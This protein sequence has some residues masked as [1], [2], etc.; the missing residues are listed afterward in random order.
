MNERGNKRPEEPDVGV[1]VAPSS[2]MVLKDQSEK[3]EELTTLVKA[4]IE[5][6]NARDRKVD[7]DMSQQEQHWKAIQQQVQQFEHSEQNVRK[8]MQGRQPMDEYDDDQ[9]DGP[10]PGSRGSPNFRC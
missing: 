3:M 5:H 4:R 2:E 9:E 6:Q 8:Q 7:K 10:V 1:A